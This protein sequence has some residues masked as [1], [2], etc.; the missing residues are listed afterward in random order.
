MAEYKKLTNGLRIVSEQIPVV[1]SVAIGFWIRAG[2]VTESE[3]NNGISHFIEH[4]LFKGTESRSA[5][6]IA[7]MVDGVG[8][9]INA[10]TSREY[11]C[12]YM[13]VLDENLSMA[14]ELLADMLFNSRFDP[15]EIEKEKSVI[16]E[17]ISMYEDSPEDLAHDLLI[18]NMFRHHPLGYSILGQSD[19][20]ESL[21][22]DAM[23]AYMKNHY[24]PEDTVISVAGNFDP[25]YLDELLHRYFYDWKGAPSTEKKT[26][27]TPTLCFGEISRAKDIEQIHLNIGYQGAVLGSSEMFDLLVINNIIGGTMS[28]RLFQSIREE[29]GLVYSIYSSMHN[30]T[31]NG[32]FT[33]YCSMNPGQLTAVRELIDSELEE[34]MKTGFTADEFEKA[35][36]QLKGSY[37]LGMESTS[38]R[39]AA[40]G[41][42][43][44]LLN[45]IDT[46]DMILKKIN[47]LEQT[48][49]ERV[50]RQYMHPDQKM[51]VLVGRVS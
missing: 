5:R 1:K 45:R 10:F 48:N 36:K 2:V 47:E 37:L 6:E 23:L 4:M 39:M 12:Y 35:R 49:A 27:T 22:R 14:V 50:M 42:S 24:R 17:E 8:G 25:A 28:S 33:L 43:E 15:E 38:G 31:S 51:A 40:M 20:I 41:K 21:T 30:Y 13:K 26:L 32:V 16:G 29:K 11:T 7:E 19:S 34:L 9:H 3:S 44:L 18:E 46:P